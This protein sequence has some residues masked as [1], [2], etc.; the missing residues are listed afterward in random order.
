MKNNADIMIPGH[1]MLTVMLKYWKL[2]RGMLRARKQG[3][4]GA[5]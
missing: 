3:A 1:G 4:F 5:F 2:P